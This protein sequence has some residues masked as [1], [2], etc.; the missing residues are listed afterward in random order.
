MSSVLHYIT[1]EKILC[2]ETHGC[3]RSI[4]RSVPRVLFLDS[5]HRNRHDVVVRN[6]SELVNNYIVRVV[7]FCAASW[8]T[9]DKVLW[10]I[11]VFTADVTKVV[12]AFACDVVAAVS[13]LHRDR[14][15][16]INL[17]MSTSL[18]GLEAVHNCAGLWYAGMLKSTVVHHRLRASAAGES[19][20]FGTAQQVGALSARINVCA[21]RFSSGR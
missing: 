11:I 18:E 6:R 1:L 14:A 19:T 20:A 12:T 5:R 9:G 3:V 2:N 16:E 21:A 17:V 10:A 4:L 15:M 7:V 13:E 8:A